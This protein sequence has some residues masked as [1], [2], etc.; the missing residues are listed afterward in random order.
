MQRLKGWTRESL[1]QSL[2]DSSQ[3]T[4]NL[5]IRFMAHWSINQVRE[6]SSINYPS[7]INFSSELR[8]DVSRDNLND[9]SSL[10][11]RPRNQ[12]VIPHSFVVIIN[13]TWFDVR[14]WRLHWTRWRRWFTRRFSNLD[15]IQKLRLPRVFLQFQAPIAT[16]DLCS[17]A[18]C[19]VNCATSS[20]KHSSL[21]SL[22]ASLGISRRGAAT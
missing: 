12:F 1:I 22:C 3:L 16:P 6:R 5:S 7:R 2:N 10:K 8:W 17:V 15:R 19:S 11:Y 4:R 9:I 18:S 21:R 13:S 20:E 14:P